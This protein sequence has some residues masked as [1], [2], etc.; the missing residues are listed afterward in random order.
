MNVEEICRRASE[1]G[2]EVQRLSMDKKNQVLQKAAQLL[3]ESSAEILEAN[4]KD[5][6]AAAA[7]GMPDSMLDRLRLWNGG[8]PQR[9]VGASG[10]LR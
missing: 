1:A 7:A 8:R 3:V 2:V 9:G 6:E 10:S 4:R 5:E